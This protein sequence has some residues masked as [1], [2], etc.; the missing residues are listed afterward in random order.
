MHASPLTWATRL[1]WLTLPATLG[2]LLGGALADRSAA[3]ATT[4]T[5]AAWLVWTAGLGSSLV[6]LPATLTTLR[7]LAPLP[8]LAGTVAAIDVAPTALGWVGLASAALAAVGA[9]TAD[10]GDDF[11]DGSSY[12]DERRMALRP[13][14]LLLL[15]PVEL[16]WALSV[17]PLL[18]GV[19]LLGAEQWV[20]GGVL[21]VVGVGT[22]WWGWRTLHR[23]AQR[24]IVFV[25]AGVTLVDPVA[26]AEPTLFRRDSIARL[27]PAPADTEALDLSAGA[28]GLIVQIDLDTPAPVL[29]AVGRNKVTAPLEVRSVLL[30]PTRPGAMLELAE[31]RR[32][33]VQRA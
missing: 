10:V 14:T 8:V 28:T 12:G 30:A 11:V 17:G 6:L 23:L 16:V 29:P 26:L 15:G 33:A 22:A 1:L 25:P 13:P 27:G 19:C 2:D 3:V 21:A 32:I 31:Q 7:V 24:W 18:A 4:L 5:V 20:L 9:F